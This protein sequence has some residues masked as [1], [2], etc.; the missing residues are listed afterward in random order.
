MISYYTGFR[1]NV[2]DTQV[3]MQ[4][5]V[6]ESRYAKAEAHLRTGLDS[7]GGI[8]SRCRAERKPEGGSD[9]RGR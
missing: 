6:T 2:I 1:E 5:S 9:C 8:G 4:W 3:T 7:R